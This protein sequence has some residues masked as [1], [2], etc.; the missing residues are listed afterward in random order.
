MF[1]CDFAFKIIALKYQIKIN[2][3]HCEKEKEVNPE[4]GS[5]HGSFGSLLSNDLPNDRPGQ[6]S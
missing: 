3:L 5:K 6:T 2:H 4:K 1:Y